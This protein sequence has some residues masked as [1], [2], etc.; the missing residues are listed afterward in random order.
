MLTEWT[1]GKKREHL[2]RNHSPVQCNRCFT[3]FHESDRATSM[4]KLEEHHRQRVQCDIGDP[5]LRE[6]ISDVQWAELDKKK[7]RKQDG[8]RIGKWFEIWDILF[9]GTQQPKTPCKYH[10]FQSH[11]LEKDLSC[12]IMC[13]SI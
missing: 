9:P 7:A 10:F 6:G 13:L 12:S 1:N 4:S 2:R 3:T 8:E 11:A 5:S